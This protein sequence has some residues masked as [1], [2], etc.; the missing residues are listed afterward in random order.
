MS[1]YQGRAINPKTGKEE[2][3]WFGNYIDDSL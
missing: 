3:A 1:S 2:V